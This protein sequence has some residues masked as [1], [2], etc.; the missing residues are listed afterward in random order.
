M[1]VFKDIW[2]FCPKI[3]RIN[4]YSLILQEQIVNIAH[5]FWQKSCLFFPIIKCIHQHYILRE[6][7]L[8][9][10]VFSTKICCWEVLP[11]CLFNLW[12]EANHLQ[13]CNSH[14]FPEKK[15]QKYCIKYH[16][17]FS[18]CCVFQIF[19]SNFL[20]FFFKCMLLIIQC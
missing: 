12:Y 9:T 1:K 3:S 14:V 15:S 6:W 7:V 18:L 20:V 11:F 10:S 16:Y 17:F 2:I 8:I 4:W 19:V 5:R 13:T